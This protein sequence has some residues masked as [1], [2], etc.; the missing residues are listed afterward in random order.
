METSKAIKPMPRMAILLRGAKM[1]ALLLCGVLQIVSCGAAI[2]EVKD[3][4]IDNPDSNRRIYHKTD[5]AFTAL[6][7]SFEHYG[8]KYVGSSFEV[9]DVPINFYEDRDPRTKGI[10]NTYAS[11]RREVLISKHYWDR[12]TYLMREALVFH[13]LGHCV[14]NRRHTE[15]YT[16]LMYLYIHDAYYYAHARERLIYELF[17]P[18]EGV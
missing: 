3:F 17:N 18:T 10:C 2:E 7:M 1:K 11:G 9:G 13:E 14:L 6:I 15:V 5:P 4:I 16:S 8:R 12:A